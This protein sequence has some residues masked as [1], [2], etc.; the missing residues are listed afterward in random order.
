MTYIANRN[1]L[2]EVSKGNIPKHSV[3]HKFGRN[4]SVANGAWEAITSYGQT[5]LT[6]LNIHLQT[7]S[8]VR[9]K[10]GGN[11]NDDASGTHAREI[12]VVGL[13]ENG[14]EQS[15]TIATNG[16]LA[17]TATTTT[18]LR[19]YRAYV[20]AVGTYGEVNAAAID[21]ENSAGTI[22]MIQIPNAVGQSL[23]GGYT[24]PL[25]VTAYV[26]DITIT[27]ESAKPSNIIFFQR[28]NILDTSVPV[29][30]ARAVHFWNGLEGIFHDVQ[31]M[32]QKFEALTD[33]WFEALGDGAATA[34]TVDFEI[35]LVED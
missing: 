19:V 14:D 13:D 30:S 4:P 26:M 5:G 8:T 27:T 24:V 21:I 25:G 11:T 3:V 28:K 15:E 12:T 33:L 32:P 31:L 35:L 10:A 6:P 16:V 17:S 1:F 7:A 20:S 22:D 23:F 29:S 18:F 2:V 9:I 34:V